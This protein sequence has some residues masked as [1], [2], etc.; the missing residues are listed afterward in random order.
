MYG[1]FCLLNLYSVCVNFVHSKYVKFNQPVIYQTLVYTVNVRA[2]PIITSRVL[3]AYYNKG[4][5][6]KIIGQKG[7]WLLTDKGKWVFK[8]LLKQV[9]N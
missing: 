1:L 4:V 5:K 7:G 9:S 8:K 6:V 3:G 2:K